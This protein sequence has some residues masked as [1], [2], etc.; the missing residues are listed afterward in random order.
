ME[1]VFYAGMDVHKDS[2]H[3]AV[4]RSS[5]PQLELETRLPYNLEKVPS[6]PVV[7]G[8]GLTAAGPF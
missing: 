8:H 2:I 3:I 5:S 7:S 6:L 4:L 1:T